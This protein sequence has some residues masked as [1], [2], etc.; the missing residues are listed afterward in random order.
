M[1]ASMTSLAGRKWYLVVGMGA[2]R[3]DGVIVCAWFRMG[4]GTARWDRIGSLTLEIPPNH[5]FELLE[6]TGFDVELPFQIGH[7]SCSIWLISRGASIP[8]P[9]MH[10]D[11]FE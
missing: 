1:T 9:T 6:G 11:L 5:G 2:D 7:I 4:E 3:N 10:Q 8:W